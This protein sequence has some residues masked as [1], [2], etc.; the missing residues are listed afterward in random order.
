MLGLTEAFLGSR[1]FPGFQYNI[2]NEKI[3]NRIKL[4]L[5]GTY[6]TLTVFAAMLH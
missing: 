3:I 4:V 2:E 1:N 5:N 6:L